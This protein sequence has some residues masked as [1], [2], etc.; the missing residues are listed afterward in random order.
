V[1]RGDF[2]ALKVVERLMGKTDLSYYDRA[3]HY[4]GERI[5][6]PEFFVFSDDIA[7]CRENLRLPFPATFAPPESAGPKDAFHLELMSLC[8]H[9]IIANSTFSWWGAWL[10][11]NPQK[12]VIA[13]RRWYA[14]AATAGDIVP[15]NWIKM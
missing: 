8:K 2:A 15:E 13:P 6:K 12:I 3:V 4:I 7:W 5:L 10:N 11:R 14:G 1:R 9:H